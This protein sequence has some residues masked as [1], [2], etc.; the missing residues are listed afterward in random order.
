MKEILSM[1]TQSPI[2]VIKSYHTTDNM[3]LDTLDFIGHQIVSF[4]TKIQFALKTN[5]YFFSSFYCLICTKG[6]LN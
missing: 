3:D 2:I 1:F 4:V 6:R 5:I